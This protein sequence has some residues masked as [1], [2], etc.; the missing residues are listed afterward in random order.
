MSSIYDPANRPPEDLTARARIRDAAMAQFAERGFKDTT[1]KGIAEGAGVST[2]LVQHHFGS[3]E[4]LQQAC[5][6]TVVETIRRQLGLVERAVTGETAS[7]DLTTAMYD[8][9]PLLIRYLVRL[10]TDG[11]PAVASL[12]DEFATGTEEVLGHFVP[13]MFPPGSRQARDGATV[14]LAMHLGVIVLHEHLSRRIGASIM[15]RASAP[16]ISLAIFDLYA[17]M[18][19]WVTSEQGAQSRAAVAAYFEKLSPPAPA[20]DQD[21]GDA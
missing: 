4:A 21:P 18:G 1:I 9:S 6:E 16:R 12:F 15:D 17:A 2:G 13:E 19:R 5:D 7:P 20:R 14:M 11:S 3:K 8:L 10:L